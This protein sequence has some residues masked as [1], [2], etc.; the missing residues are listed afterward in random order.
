MSQKQPDTLP[1]DTV[2]FDLDGVVTK[3]AL[4]HAAAWKEMFDEYLR[5][6]QERDQEPF[7]E[8]THE[9][10]YLP[11]VDGKPRYKG[12]QSFLESRN[13]HI[14]LGT[15]EDAPDQETV[16]GLGNRKN[17]KFREVLLE[18]GVEVYPST[19][20]LIKDLKARGI[21]IGV[22]SSSKNCQYVLQAAGIEDL[23]E[24]RVDGVVSAEMGLKGKPEADIFVTAAKNVGS[25]PSRAIVVE[26]AV[27]GVQAGRNGKFLLVIGLAREKNEKELSENG[28]DVVITD[29]EGFLAD[30]LAEWVNEKKS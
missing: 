14:P 16:C 21:R 10:D 8:F 24:T 19:V 13:V 3:T 7:R 2:I 20:A 11:Y 5:M 15:P 12:V 28:A 22:A 9:N 18:K 26:D 1:F 17:I 29:F 6:R 23:F 25:D 4:V 27:S 30:Q